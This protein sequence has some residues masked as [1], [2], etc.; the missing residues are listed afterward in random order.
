M[1]SNGPT[2]ETDNI[3]HVP[4]P[5]NFSQRSPLSPSIKYISSQDTII[6]L[7]IPT[8]VQGQREEEM[9]KHSIF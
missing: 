9:P 1:P 3:T 2:R 7:N 5:G 8:L 4:L 6:S